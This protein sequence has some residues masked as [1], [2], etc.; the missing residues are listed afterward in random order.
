MTVTADAMNQAGD[1][2]E[3]YGVKGMRW[4]V[5]RTDAQLG[6]AAKKESDDGGGGKGGESGGSESRKAASGKKV[7]DLSDSELKKLTERLNTE[8][9]YAKLTAPPPA[10]SAAIKKFVSEIVVNVAR[11]QITQVANRQASSIINDALFTSKG[12]RIPP[13]PNRFPNAPPNP[14]DKLG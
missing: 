10:K 6:R 13:P 11:T 12:P 9:Q 2:L 14:L 1:F 5:R 4:G 3:Q 7:S 8:Q